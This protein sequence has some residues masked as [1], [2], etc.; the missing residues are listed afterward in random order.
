MKT[1]IFYTITLIFAA[2][3]VFS[4]CAKKLDIFPK[5]G[6]SSDQVYSTPDGY[7][8][9]LGK[10]YQ[11][12]STTGNQ[13][14]A[15]DPDIAGGLDE[16]SQV[17]FIRGFFNAQELPTDEA[18]VAWND[19]T[20]HD[21]HYLRW[22][23]ADPFLKG[24]YARPIWN[25]TLANELIREAT[26]EKIAA[27]GLTGADAETV[28]NLR[29]EAR[30]LRAFN[31]WVMLDLF[32]KSTFITENDGI[33]STNPKEIS[34]TELFNYI[35]SELKA[36]D[37][38]LPAAKTAEYGRV[39]K[40]AAWG[41]LA[42]LYLN[43]GV[44]TGTP[45]Y[46]DALANA[47]K[48]IGAGYT[49]NSDYR[50]MFMADN[51]ATSKNE[52][53]FVAP[54]DGLTGSAFGNT[55]FLIHAPAGADYREFGAD[56]G[57]FGYRATS[58]FAEKWT[59]LSG[60][61]DKRA[62]F[63]TSVFNATMAQAQIADI[64]DFSNGLHVIKY[65]NLR[66]DGAP[67]RD[68]NSKFSDIDFPIMR[69]P[70]MY[71]IYAEANLRGGGGSAATGLGYINAI[72][73]RAGATP[74]GS[75]DYTLQFVLDERAREL[76]WEGHRRTDLIRYNLLTTSNYLWPWKGGVATGTPVDSKYNIYP[77][78]SSNLNSNPNL[79]QNTGY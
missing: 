37:A 18:V 40:A 43:A 24:I 62:M 64:A 57:W 10:L 50:K 35:E 4:S 77:I 53:I 38:E 68:L 8:A 41:L 58:A 6:L 32:G 73:N 2:A 25:I 17:A 71:F 19:Q 74:I 11:T 14:P 16:G 13:G 60:A 15:G 26:D 59:D 47:V 21:F 29:G 45:R 34:R 12:L 33:G 54:C 22:T 79:T 69:L 39:D 30:F 55:T 46:A 65:R 75:T 27:H 48:V 63:K 36:I 23:S 3:I 44:Y 20:I 66:S 52:F 9:V 78:P 61:T 31:Y 76:Y 5:N 51:D 56:D 49:L 72:R 28:K 7:K 42:K 70:E 1:K 67:V